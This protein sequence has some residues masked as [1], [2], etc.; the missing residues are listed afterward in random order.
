VKAAVRGD[1]LVRAVSMEGAPLAGQLDRALVG[2][3]AAVAKEHVLESARP[4]D[5]RGQVRHALV[6]EGGTAVDQAG[7]LRPDGVHHDRVA[8]AQAVDGP[9]LHEVQVR[10]ALGVTQPGA[11]PLG[12][13]DRRPGGDRHDV[14]QRRVHVADPPARSWTRTTG[15]ANQSS[16]SS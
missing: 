4:G 3:R 5:Q 11:G 7:R 16:L 13:D 14:L 9:A 15:Q 6:V 2:L 8:V 12:H 10:P 1:D